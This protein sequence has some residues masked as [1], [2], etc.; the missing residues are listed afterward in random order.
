[1]AE[2]LHASQTGAPAEVIAREEGYGT[3]TVFIHSEQSAAFGAWVTFFESEAKRE[4]AMR[5][6]DLKFGSAE[7]PEGDV[8]RSAVV[9]YITRPA[10]QE[11]KET[12]DRCIG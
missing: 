8:R 6:L 11:I 4:K 10:Q 7:V 12:I 9:T 3:A 2:A 5:K 1:M